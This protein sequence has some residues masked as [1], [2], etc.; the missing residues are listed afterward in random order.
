MIYVIWLGGLQWREGTHVNLYR[1]LSED[2]LQWRGWIPRA[3]GL[4]L[5]RVVGHGLVARSCGRVL[6]FSAS[7]TEVLVLLLLR[8]K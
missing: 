5:G 1:G 2:V 6:R 4:L 8:L 7:R 3:R